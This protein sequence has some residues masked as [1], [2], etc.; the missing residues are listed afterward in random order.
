MTAS[1]DEGSRSEQAGPREPA[2]AHRRTPRHEIRALLRAH[3][4]A[5]TGYRHLTRHCAV[6]ARLLRLAM[7]PVTPSRPRNRPTSRPGRPN[8]PLSPGRPLRGRRWRGAGVRRLKPHRTSQPPPCGP[9]ATPPPRE[10]QGGS[11]TTGPGPGARRTKVPPPHDQWRAAVV[12][13]S[14]TLVLGKGHAV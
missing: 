4:A 7:E 2:A 13:C 12:P 9:G 8:R 3:L 1:T 14:G 6:C 11:R 10:A 5:A